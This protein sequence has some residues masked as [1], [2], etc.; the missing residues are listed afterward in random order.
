MSEQQ[1]KRNNRKT[2]EI[3]AYG[4]EI[5]YDSDLQYSSSDLISGLNYYNYNS[6]HDNLKNYVLEYLQRDSTEDRFN[7]LFNLNK[8]AF[9]GTTG[10]MCRMATM[11][12]PFNK[13]QISQIDSQIEQLIELAKLKSSS[14]DQSSEKPKKAEKK[15]DIAGNIIAD[16][17][18][19]IDHCTTRQKFTKFNVEE[20]I[21]HNRIKKPITSQ[22]AEYYKN[23]LAIAGDKDCYSTGKMYE[24]YVSFLSDLIEKF[25]S[26]EY[27]PVRKA[28]AKKE[29][30]PMKLVSKMKYCTE[31]CY[32]IA[33]LHP[34]EILGKKS[35]V[36]FNMRYKTIQLLVAEEGKTLTVKGSTIYNIDKEKSIQ[37][38]VRKPEEFLDDLLNDKYVAGLDTKINRLSTK[39]T[40]PTGSVNSNTIILKVI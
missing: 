24:Q 2:V 40:T 36:L 1:N 26:V 22:I 12:F 37:K 21:V 38:I 16:I 3:I 14:V 20:Y 11:G 27:V 28:R 6:S 5:K 29:V 35:V 19:F 10:S 7:I 32:S 13:K 17:D 23:S 33:S 4:E 30:E 9:K 15:I 34:V 8:T 39:T 31:G 18:Q 25:S